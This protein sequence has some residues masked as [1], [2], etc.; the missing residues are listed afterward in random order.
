[1]L[2][3]LLLASMAV[4]G[5]LRL[6]PGDPAAVI[7]G[8]DASQEAVEA[9]RTQFGL[10]RALPVQYGYWAA[11]A[12]QGNLGTSYVTGKPVSALIVERA[13]A[14]LE[15]A[16]SAYVLMV[17]AGV[18]SG[19]VAALRRGRPADMAITTAN[20]IALS[21]PS[22]WTG[23]ILLLVFGVKLGW[24]PLAGRVPLLEDPRDALAHLLLPAITLALAMTPELSWFVR[25]SVLDVMSND[26]VRTARAKGL[27]ESH[28]FNR[29]V[30][31]NALIPIL[32]ILGL[33]AGRLLG[34][35]VV[36]ESIFG[37]PGLGRLLLQSIL[38][39][40]Y[41][42]VQGILLL[43]VMIFVVVNLIVDLLYVV[44]DPRLR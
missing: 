37:W 43:I 30:L 36:V 19:V 35:A 29:H 40:D 7:A 25:N 2:P 8:P 28:V 15:L 23:L 21:I 24:L 41:P 10:D 5:L 39:R 13:P 12:I 32:T 18:S 9:I 22:F 42:T 17:V 14:T 26:Y 16:L 6:V 44:V 3:V 4:F 11:Q 1:M 33:Q 20:T 27:A 31:R 34:G 38:N